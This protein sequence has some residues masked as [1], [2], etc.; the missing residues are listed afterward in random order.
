MTKSRVTP[1]VPASIGTHRQAYLLLVV[2]ALVWGGHWAVTKV[3]LRDIPPFT[4]GALRVATGLATLAVLLAARGR[5]RRPP[6]SDLPV[7][8]SVGI[9]QIAAGIALMNLALQVVPAGRSSV[10]LYTMPL[11]VAIIQATVLRRGLDPCQAGGVALG[12]VGIAAL[13]NPTVIDWSNPGQLVGSVALLASAIIW[14]ATTI[15]LRHHR[16]E[17]SPLELLP[18]QL[19]VALVPLAALAIGLEGN[20]P[21]HWGIGALLVVAYSGPLASGFGYWATQSIT[22]TLNPIETTMGFLAV[23]VV[24]LAS[25]TIFLGEPMG[26]VDVVGFVVTVGAIAVVSLSPGSTQEADS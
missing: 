4:Y 23:P 26:L 15:Q 6:R 14:A 12:L 22:R 9:G 13:L 21:V 1:S 5:L 7:V 11:W 2:L 25:G 24:G 16:W 18:W 10:L 17:A 8:L 20:Q 3:G 19:L